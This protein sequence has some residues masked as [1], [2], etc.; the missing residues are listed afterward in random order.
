MSD[1]VY[2]AEGGMTANASATAALAAGRKAADAG[3]LADAVS[4]FRR[5]T[6][7]DPK[8]ADGW[9]ELARVLALVGDSAA[10][11]D[12]LWQAIDLRPSILRQ[13]LPDLM[14]D[15]AAGYLSDTTNT[16]DLVTRI[17]DRFMAQQPW[18]ANLFIPSIETYQKDAEQA[19]MQYS[20][21]AADDFLHP[22]FDRITRM[23]DRTTVFHRKLWEWVYVIHHLLRSGMVTPGRRGLAFG[24]GQEMLP[25]L[26][27]SHGAQI[28]ATDA[29]VDIGEAWASTNQ[30]ASGLAA[31]P[32]GPLPREQF[33]RLVSWQPCDMT[34]IDAE[35][36]GYDFCWSSCCFEHLGSLRA[37]MDFV[38]NSVEHCLKPGGVAVHTTELNLSSND[39]TIANGPTVLYRRKD[40]EQLI[41]ELRDRGHRV[42]LLRIAPDTLGVDNYVDL[43]PY[44]GPHLKLLLE[45]YVATSVGLVVRKKAA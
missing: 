38:I 44:A 27:A 9:S 42:D 7:D 25:A 15:V 32:E 26:F 39:V 11:E 20:T 41:E 10:S 29:P 5:V 2:R 21:C 6:M 22:E 30:F 37:G 35:L 33:E 28:T 13:V 8:F 4:A 34:N 12:A 18:R 17:T 16:D 40:I 3:N 24:V 14:R 19:F 31:L 43:P 23:I 1:E 45:G 36:T